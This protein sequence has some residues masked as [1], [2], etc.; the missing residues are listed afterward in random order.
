LFTVQ[1]RA[2]HGSAMVERGSVGWLDNDQG[3]YAVLTTT[4]PGGL[5]HTTYTPGRYER[6]HQALQSLIDHR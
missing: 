5:R 4:D 3:R 6:F 1:R 2:R